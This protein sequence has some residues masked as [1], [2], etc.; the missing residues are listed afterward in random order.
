MAKVKHLM[1]GLV[2]KENHRNHLEELIGLKDANRVILSAAFLTSEGVFILQNSLKQNKEKISFY[3]GCRNGVTS[4][5][6]VTSLID[7]GIKPI[8]VDTGSNNFIF[9][10]KVFFAQSD[11]LA[12]STVGSANFTY[13]GLIR[14]L[15]SSALLELDYSV[16]EDKAYADDLLASFETLSSSFPENVFK[17]NTIE[18]AQLLFNEGRLV[19]ERA[20]KVM[21]KGKSKGSKKVAP[22]MQLE[23]DHFKVPKREKSPVTTEKTETVLVQNKGLNLLEVWKSKELTKRDLNIQTGGKTHVTGSMLLKKGTYDVDQQVYF[24]EEVFSDLDWQPKAGKPPYFHYA[25]ATFYF[26]VEGVDFGSYL[27]EMKHDTRTNTTTY[28]QRQPMTHLLWGESRHL[29]SNPN[30]LGKTLRLMKVKGSNSEFLI[31]ID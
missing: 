10:P 1:Q 27:L 3:V 21:V 15:E 28:Q 12:L 8:L 18:E 29:V 9:H 23:H 20:S 17:V 2:K 14:N 26:V 30:L 13:G 6:G 16:E 5:Q 25:N 11:N 24:Y 31:E 7:I 19:D 4:L 22:P